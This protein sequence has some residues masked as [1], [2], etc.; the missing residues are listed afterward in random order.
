MIKKN[1]DKANTETKR[2]MAGI[3]KIIAWPSCSYDRTN[4]GYPTEITYDEFAYRR[5]VDT[6]REALRALIN[7]DK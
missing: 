4:N 1:C 5:L 6:Y 7:G 2:L 3:K